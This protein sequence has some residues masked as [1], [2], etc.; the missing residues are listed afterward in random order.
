[1]RN[2]ETLDSSIRATLG[3][4]PDKF[5]LVQL[6]DSGESLGVGERPLEEFTEKLVL[7][8]VLKLHLSIAVMRTAHAARKGIEKN[9]FLFE[10]VHG[11]LEWWNDGRGTAPLQV[12]EAGDVLYAALRLLANCI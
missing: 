10:P 12:H 1:M 4:D 5:S 7:R 2:L 11:R 3:E 9:R 6:R 8:Y